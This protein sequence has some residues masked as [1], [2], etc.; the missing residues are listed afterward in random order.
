MMFDSPQRH[1]CTA[2]VSSAGSGAIMSGVN[3]WGVQQTDALGYPLN[4]AGAGAR[5]DLDGVDN[6][7]F[8]YAPSGKGPDVEDCEN[9]Q[10]HLH[11]FQRRLRDYV[12][13][14]KYRGGIG[15][16]IACTPHLT[17]SVAYMNFA[18]ESLFP[19]HSG[20]FG[21]YPCSTHP[22]IQVNGT[23]VHEKMARGDADLPMSSVELMTDK[24]LAGDYVVESKTR[25]VRVLG[26]DDV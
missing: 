10:G 18:K 13:F 15:L 6:Y 1:L 23:D 11:L 19:A 16:T 17:P 21:G 5:H 14:G 20:L 24:T 7:G 12:G 25:K 26:K 2:Y 9:E 8:P 3:Q 4:A 22:G